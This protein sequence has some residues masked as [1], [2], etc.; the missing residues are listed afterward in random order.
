MIDIPF[1]TQTPV[2]PAI[3][4]LP[5][6]SN[7]IGTLSP[8]ALALPQG[9]VL[10]GVVTQRDSAGNVSLSTNLGNITLN[11]PLALTTGSEIGFR[12]LSSLPNLQIQL[13]SINGTPVTKDSLAV[14]AR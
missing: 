8:A 1:I 14:I 3:T 9:A 12:I 13:A 7:I 4:P 11:T 6:S 5:P 10:T 2:L